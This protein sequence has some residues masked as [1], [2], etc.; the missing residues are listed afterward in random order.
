MIDRRALVAEAALAP[1]V[2]N[3]QP[4][5][6][7]L[8]DDDGLALF[9]DVRCRLTVGDPRG[10]DAGIS[11]GAAAEGMRIAAGRHG[12]ALVPVGV[13]GD[14]AMLRGVA[15]WRLVA[16]GEGDPL[17]AAVEARRSWRGKF[18]AP[19]PEDRRAAAALA[20]DDAA[21]LTDPATLKRLAKRY[22]AASYGFMRERGFRGELLSWMRLDRGHPRWAT[23]GL[24]AEAMAMGSI[25][26]RGAALVLGPGFRLLDRIGL[27]RPL[28][29]EGAKIAG[30]A[31]LV[32]FHRPADEAPFD[33]GA[34]FY[35]LW[36]R[37]EAAGFGAAVLAALADD[38]EAAAAVV[39]AAGL[40]EDRR[41]VSAFRIGRRP[42][43]EQPARARRPIDELLV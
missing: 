11:L 14:E 20:A 6:W 12:L 16:G 18:A 3:V 10:N 22:D 26:A 38:Q 43:G 2:H 28:L 34:A 29:A 24:N 41:I 19:S 39:R 32:V 25:E 5:R 23:D 7:R 36:L 31:G 4:A 37:I 33:S 9:E 30:A 15:G 1:S 21:V 35:R 17:A 42:I 27:A 13:P 40:G 8:V